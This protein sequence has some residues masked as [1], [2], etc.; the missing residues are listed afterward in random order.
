M[1]TRQETLETL[2]RIAGVDAATLAPE[3]HLVVDLGIDSPK[4]LRLLVELEDRL[5]VEIED[6]DAAGLKTVGDVLAYV[7]RVGG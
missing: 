6:E 7:A 1:T 4:A 3:Q 5:D 2:A